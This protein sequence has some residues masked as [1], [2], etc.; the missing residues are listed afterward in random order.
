[1]SDI[2]KKITA[3]A[4]RSVALSNSIDDVIDLEMPSNLWNTLFDACTSVEA[5]T[6]YLE[7]A[8]GMAPND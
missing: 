4:N 7:T 3:L 2:K 5:A 1:M 8:E 6:R